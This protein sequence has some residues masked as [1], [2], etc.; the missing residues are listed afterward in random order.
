MWQFVDIKQSYLSLVAWPCGIVSVC[1]AMGREIES[2]Q[3]I[4]WWI[5][6]LNSNHNFVFQANDKR[7]GSKV[8]KI[9]EI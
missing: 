3:S 9:A 1:G 7:F 2:R 6:L 8:R 4:V 5:F